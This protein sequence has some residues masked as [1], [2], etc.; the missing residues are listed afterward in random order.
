MFQVF[1][2]IFQHNLIV[3]A[4]L[5]GVG[6]VLFGKVRRVEEIVVTP[7]FVGCISVPEASC[8]SMKTAEV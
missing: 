6:V 5:E 7:L 2:G 8:I 3:Q 1:N 4:V